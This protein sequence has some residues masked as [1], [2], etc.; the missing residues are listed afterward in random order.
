MHKT[1]F[2]FESIDWAQKT[3]KIRA[4]FTDV[5]THYD[6]MNDAMSGGL[7]R[8]WK[9]SMVTSLPVRPNHTI[10]DV[11]GGTGDIAFRL[12]KTYPHLNLSVTVCDL[13]ENMLNVGRDRALNS[14]IL[15]PLQW[16]CGNAEHLP[17]P[18]NSIDIY[19]IAFGLRNV[20]HIDRALKEANRVLKPGGHFACLEF[21]SVNLAWLKLAY[22]TYSFSIIPWIGEKIARN[23]QAYQYLVESIRRFPSQEHLGSHL[24]A[25]GFKDVSWQNY[26][27]GVSCLHHAK[28]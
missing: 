25:A 10:L 6:V 14:G 20:T 18:D 22:D 19:T 27:G 23:R 9:Q 3:E 15:S 24:N 11:A 7:H 4:L 2:G 8:C 5:S 1:H 16:V 13:T 28:K 17:F 26:F 21:S 12:L